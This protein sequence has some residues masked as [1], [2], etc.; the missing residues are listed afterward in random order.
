MIGTTSYTPTFYV[1]YLPTGNRF[2]R[3]IGGEYSSSGAARIA[4]REYAAKKLGTS[5]V[6]F[7]T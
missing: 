2:A 4:A 6:K 5:D 1:W 3:K 7:V